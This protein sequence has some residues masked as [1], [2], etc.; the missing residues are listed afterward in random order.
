MINLKELNFNLRIENR[1]KTVDAIEINQIWTSMLHVIFSLYH[2]RSILFIS[3][4]VHF[5]LLFF[6]CTSSHT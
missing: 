3:L 1:H 4:V 2:L 6:M 5:H